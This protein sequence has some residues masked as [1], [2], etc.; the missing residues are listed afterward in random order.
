MK[1]LIA[2]LLSLLVVFSL[3]V[4]AFAAPS[5]NLI[6]KE[7]AKKIALDH[8]GYE[9]SEV[10]FIK[11]KLDFDDGRYEYEIEFRADGN[12][13]YDYSI[14]A[15]NGKVVEF[16]RDYDAPDRFEAFWFIGFLRNL[17]A[18]LFG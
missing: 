2:L 7:E 15:V 18:R 3:S 9:E 12:L 13:E 10:R 1:K 8:A 5:E 4:S 16:D 6:S 14:N 17:L 11:A